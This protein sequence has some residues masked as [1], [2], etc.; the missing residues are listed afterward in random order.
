MGIPFAQGMQLIFDSHLSYT[1]GALE[2]FLRIDNFVPQGD[3]IEVGVSFAPTGGQDSQAGFTDLLI[4]PPP[5]TQPVS[6]HDIGLSGGKLMFGARKFFVSHTFVQAILQSYP[7]IRGGYNVFRKW[8]NSTA[9]VMGIIYNNQLYSI[10]D[11]GR[12][13]IAGETIHWVLTCNSSEEYLDPGS[14]QVLQP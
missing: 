5:G 2:V 13:E 11:I 1:R 4:L 14:S 7:N 12:R 10:E 6:Y 8:D 9:S 3:Y